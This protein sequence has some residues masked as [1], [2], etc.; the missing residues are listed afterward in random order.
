[1]LDAALEQCARW[2]EAGRVPAVAVNVSPRN[3][4]DDHFVEEV[5]ELLARW[6]V[7]ASCLEF[8]VT[9]SAITADPDRAGG[10]SPGWPTAA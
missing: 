9:E 3:L 6:R 5:Q 1:V 8:E 7:P 4:L 2:R 10:S